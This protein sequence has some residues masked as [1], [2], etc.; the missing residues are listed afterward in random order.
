MAIENLTQIQTVE[1]D[2]FGDYGLNGVSPYGDEQKKI[3]KNTFQATNDVNQY[4]IGND[5]VYSI[6]LKSI[7]AESSKTYN[8]LI[9][10]IND[11]D[12]LLN[13]VNITPSATATLEETHRHIWSELKQN[14]TMS[15][16]I[17]MPNFVNYNQYLYAQNHRCRGCRKFVKEYDQLISTTTFG[18]IYAF[19]KIITYL[20]NETERI[21]ES[22]LNDFGDDYEDESQQQVA[23]YYLYWLKMAIHYKGIF[24]K[25]I[26]ASPVLLPESEV[27]QVSKRQAAQFQTFFSIRV[28]SETVSI[29]NQLDSLMKDLIEDCDVFYKKFLSPSI[30]FKTK[31]GGDLS[32][33]FRT[34]NM[35]TNMPKLAEEAITAVLAI[36]GN[37]KSLLTD[38]LERRSIMVKKIEAIYQSILQRR[39]YVLYI[40]QLSAKAL[41]KNTIV[42]SEFDQKYVDVLLYAVADR[43]AITENLKSS[44]SIL[45]DLGEDSHPQY[46]L[47]SG[48]KI[49]GNIEV[50]QDVTIDGI[51]L[52]SHSH[53]GYDG[54]SRIRSIDIDYSTI[55]EDYKT[56][57]LLN[58]KNVLDINIESF[59]PDILVG[60]TPVADATVSIN[61]PDDLA[62][63]YTFEILYTEIK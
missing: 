40:S 31:V 39:K 57:G 32:L 60:G 53:N 59:T 34:S 62:Q 48:G 15:D 16:G 47:K 29:N 51:D 36:E 11:L 9:A 33:D 30:K 41:S 56:N 35:V 28:N 6:P 12:T 22:L 46:L 18:H 1:K 19:R 63:K 54:S 10:F 55:R 37:F 24:E 25:S 17:S 43:S 8:D 21:Q 38:L 5:Q 58:V 49:T 50:D 13:Q 42:T 23:T 45:D 3:Q 27:D 20:L 44:H 61:V 26:P 52:S 14:Q 2:L 4:A 7:K